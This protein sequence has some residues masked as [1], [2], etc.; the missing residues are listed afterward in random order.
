MDAV[1]QIRKETI[2]TLTR[3]RQI[4]LPH[5]IPRAYQKMYACVTREARS[6]QKSFRE[7]CALGSM[8]LDQR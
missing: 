3:I 4:T 8:R 2:H 1:R 5:V 7:Q 6:S